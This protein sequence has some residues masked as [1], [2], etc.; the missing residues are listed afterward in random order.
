MVRDEVEVLADRLGSLTHEIILWLEGK[1][2]EYRRARKYKLAN[3]LR[4]L[5][6]SLG[7]AAYPLT[8]YAT[9]ERNIEQLLVSYGSFY[10]AVTDILYECSD[11]DA[12]KVSGFYGEAVE[13]ATKLVMKALGVTE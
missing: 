11:L 10:K 12:D 4:G 5:A 1:A 7:D 13:L 9:K 6:A 2:E 8:Y 3:R